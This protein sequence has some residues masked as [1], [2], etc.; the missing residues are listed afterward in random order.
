MRHGEPY[1]HISPKDNSAII[2]RHFALFLYF[3][4]YFASN[5]LRRYCFLKYLWLLVKQTVFFAS[6]RLPKCLRL[7]IHLTNRALHAEHSIVDLIECVV[8]QV[9]FRPGSHDFLPQNLRLQLA[10]VL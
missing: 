1:G 3:L 4:H 7:S 2:S 6:L 9:I 5:V 10:D 8:R